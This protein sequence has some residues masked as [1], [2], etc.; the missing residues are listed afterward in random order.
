MAQQGRNKVETMKSYV[1]LTQTETVRRVRQLKSYL[2]HAA[3]TAVPGDNTAQRH[4][5]S[6]R[7]E[8]SFYQPKV[9][10]LALC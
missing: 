7:R 10:A 3:N 6:L 8:L 2:E 5:R 4:I 1:I 9:E